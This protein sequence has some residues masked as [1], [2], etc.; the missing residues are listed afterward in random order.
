MQHIPSHP[1]TSIPN[2]M[3]ESSTENY[4]SSIESIN[5]SDNLHT[6][7]SNKLDRS[8]CHLKDLVNDSKS[9]DRIEII[10]PVRTASLLQVR[11]S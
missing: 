5:I 10:S 3:N 2:Y 6:N 8:Y 11:I 9:I 4:I 1:I 7:N